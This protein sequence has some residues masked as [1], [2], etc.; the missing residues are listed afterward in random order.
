M[1]ATI[2]WLLRRDGMTARVNQDIRRVYTAKDCDV[3]SKT[4][5]ARSWLPD[6][7]VG[8]HK[9]ELTTRQVAAE[10]QRYCQRTDLVVESYDF[11]PISEAGINNENSP[12]LPNDPTRPIPETA[13]VGDNKPAADMPSGGNFETLK[14][15][16]QERVTSGQPIDAPY[17][18]PA[19]VTVTAAPTSG[20]TGGTSGGSGAGKVWAG[21]GAAI[22]A[23]A[24]GAALVL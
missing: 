23:A 19:A 12:P 9:R 20:G 3:A 17:V 10:L 11:D 8:P 5:S 22:G 15:Q 6:S 16:V 18:T 2:G 13:E 24:V 7:Q 4:L 1:R 21:V 14:T